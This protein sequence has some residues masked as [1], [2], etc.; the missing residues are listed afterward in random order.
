VARE[1]VEIASTRSEHH[2]IVLDAPQHLE[3]ECDCERMAQVFANLLANALTYSSQGEARMTLRRD[4]QNA[5]VSLRD[6]GPGIPKDKLDSIFEPRVRLEPERRQNLGNGKGLG[7]SIAREIVEGHG[8][9][10]WAESDA[11]EATTFHLTLPLA[12]PGSARTSSVRVDKLVAETAASHQSHA[13]R[14]G[15]KLGP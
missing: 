13:R 2:T 3:A 1:Q 6:E 10:I 12:Q 11:G 9:Q 5:H 4:G 7:L 8:G 15:R 14:R